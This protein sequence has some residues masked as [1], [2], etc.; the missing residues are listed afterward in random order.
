MKT[1]QC[2]VIPTQHAPNIN[3]L[4]AIHYGDLVQVR[5]NR[6]PLW[7]QVA[8]RIGDMITG[9]IYNNPLPLTE[10][11]LVHA[12]VVRFPVNCVLSIIS[13]EDEK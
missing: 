5:F 13:T 7:I 8:Q 4:D 3:A 6:Q 10:N 11:G 1:P 2:C 12:D 9:S